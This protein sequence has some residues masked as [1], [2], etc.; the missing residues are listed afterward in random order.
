MTT[1]VGNRGKLNDRVW[2]LQI[3]FSETASAVDVRINDMGLAC[4]E[5]LFGLLLPIVVCTG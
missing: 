5:F 1:I 3:K 2:E 4:S